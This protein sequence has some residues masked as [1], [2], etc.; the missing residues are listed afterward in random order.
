MANKNFEYRI[1][2]YPESEVVEKSPTSRQ[3]DEIYVE[4]TSVSRAISKAKREGL[5]VT[6]D[7]VVSVTPINAGRYSV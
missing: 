5:I 1:A 6:K 7:L 4:A 2:F 3:S